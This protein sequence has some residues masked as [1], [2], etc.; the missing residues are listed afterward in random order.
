[1]WF[2]HGA[3]L[4]D[5]SATQTVPRHLVRQP[6]GWECIRNGRS[7]SLSAARFAASRLL[8][9]WPAL[10]SSVCCQLWQFL[11][12]DDLIHRP[13]RSCLRMNQ[14]LSRRLQNYSDRVPAYCQVSTGPHSKCYD[15]SLP[16]CTATTLSAAKRIQLIAYF[17]SLYAVWI[18]I[19]KLETNL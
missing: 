13:H 2:N 18:N 19:D 14:N 1:M 3:R 5:N 9:D 17:S 7:V 8:R 16:S 15:L 6:L 10:G 4:A 12:I 11:I